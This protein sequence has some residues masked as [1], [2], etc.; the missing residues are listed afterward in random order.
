MKIAMIGQKGIPTLFGG[1]ERHVEEISCNLAK[2][3]DFKNKV[4]VYVRNYYTP[5]RIKKYQGVNIIHLPSLKTKHLD[6]ISHVFLS[7]FHAIF[8]LKPDIIHYHGVG[9]ALCIWIP[10]ILSPKT[11][12]VFT[13][14]CQ[15]YFHKKWG[16]VARLFLKTGEMIGCLMADEIIAVSNEIKKYIEQKYNKESLFIPHGVRK[17]KYVS[18]K[19]IKKWNLEKNNYILAVSRLI[20]HKGLH[21][22]IKAY[23][24]IKTDKKLV[25]VGPSFYTNDYEDELKKISEDNSNIIFLGAQQGTVLKSLYSNAYL[26]INPSEQEGLPLTVLE[27]AS[28]G[29]PI[30]LSNIKIHSLM[31]DDFPFLFKNKNVLDLKKKLKFILN[32]PKK[33]LSR[34]EK[35][36]KY[37]QK[38]Y[39]WDKVVER[40]I[41]KYI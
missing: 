5:K 18:D 32:H 2:K 15:D 22:L 14:H 26:F 39:N 20:R 16:L 7:S 6:A 4:F 12:I 21:Y 8:K 9:P 40:T 1:I 11:K 17:E 33:S 31:L 24:E 19:F 25:I 37:A 13:F 36:K 3:K 28:F 35:T 23:K 10:K 34:G 27:A 41:L 30:L 29:K 38:I